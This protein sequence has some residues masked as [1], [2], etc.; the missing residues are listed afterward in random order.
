VGVIDHPRQALKQG[1]ADGKFRSALSTLRIA[2]RS[3]R[4]CIRPTR[5]VT[6]VELAEL[7]LA[8]DEALGRLEPDMT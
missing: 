4:C 1:T 5:P 7:E 8:T 2:E 3:P 6:D